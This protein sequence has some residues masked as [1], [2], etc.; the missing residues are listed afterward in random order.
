MSDWLFAL[1]CVVLPGVWGAVM[2]LAFRAYDKQRRKA[3]K[4]DDLPPVDYSI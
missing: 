4:R 2:F 1:A 3:G